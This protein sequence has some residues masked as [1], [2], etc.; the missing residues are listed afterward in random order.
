[1]FK[2]I[3]RN[4]ANLVKSDLDFKKTWEGWQKWCAQNEN[5]KDEGKAKETD[6]N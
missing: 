6:E 4:K 1:M 3:S 5:E 2:A